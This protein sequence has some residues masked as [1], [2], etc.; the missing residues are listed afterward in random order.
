MYVNVQSLINKLDRL[1]ILLLQE[2]YHILCFSEHW[3]ADDVLDGVNLEGYSISSCYCRKGM[4]HGGVVVYSKALL[5]LKAID[6]GE[7]C[8]DSDYECCCSTF[9]VNKRT[10]ALLLVYRS[11][12]GCYET[13]LDRLSETLNIVSDHCDHIIMCGDI[14]LDVR[15]K[16]R[17]S[18][19]T[20]DI[21]ESFELSGNFNEPTRVA[22]D[23]NG[24]RSESMIDYM[25]TNVSERE[26]EFTL[27]DV[28]IADHYA[29]IMDLDV[30][31]TESQPK[32]DKVTLRDIR[33]ENLVQ[34]KFQLSLV[35]WNDVL[36]DA[37]NM[38]VMF[39]NFNYVFNLIYDFACPYVTRKNS[40]GSGTWITKELCNRRSE[41]MDWFY[42]SKTYPELITVYKLKKREYAQD[43]LETKKSYFSRR[44]AGSSN[45]SRELWRCV[46]DQL[47]RGLKNT[48][49]L[50]LS[51]EGVQVTLPDQVCDIFS[52]HFTSS[53]ANSINSTFGSVK[54]QKCTLSSSLCNTIIF[55]PISREEILNSIKSLKMKHSTGIDGLHVG[56][57][58]F[59]ADELIDPLY[60]LF[61]KSID[62]GV[63]PTALKIA[64][65]IPVF[66][67]NDPHEITNYRPISIQNVLSKVFESVVHSRLTTFF[68]KY[69][70]FSNAQHGFLPSKSTE[71]ASINFLQF[72]YD[73]RDEGKLVAGVFFDLSQAFD[74]LD[75]EFVREKFHAVG[76]R[77]QILDWI[78]SYLTERVSHVFVSGAV[79]QPRKI[80]LGIPQGSI[81]GPLIFTI[82]INDLPGAFTTGHVTLY[83][84]DTSVA[85]SADS[86]ENLGSAVGRAVTEM[87]NWCAKNRLLLNH[88]KTV[89]VNFAYRNPV[90]LIDDKL[91]STSV[92]FLGTF[93]DYRLTFEEQVSE[94]CK[95]I[96]K[97]YF[98]IRQLKNSLTT[99]YLLNIYYALIN[100]VLCYNVLIWGRAQN[101]ERVLIAQK[102]V[103][104]LIFDV[105]YR[106]SCR[107][108]FI[109][110]DILT[111]PSIYIYKAVQYVHTKIISFKLPE[112]GYNTRKNQLYIRRH[113]TTLFEKSPECSF[114]KLYNALPASLRGITEIKK[115]KSNV[116]QYL[117]SKCFYSYN[118]FFNDQNGISM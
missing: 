12:S 30:G 95:K 86:L 8:I 17:R 40:G 9:V 63:F 75:L 57:L 118:E 23:C 97:N 29:W 6:L 48:K 110:R 99:E 101:Y 24:K 41:L 54:H 114:T 79:S 70:I 59:V 65:T 32:K 77:G 104:R 100:S 74:S 52:K 117:L 10:Y 37:D 91:F 45:V 105:P 115:F 113:K 26:R 71:T 7:L 35:D 16:C 64:K 19:L 106:E 20:L 44:I 73:Q 27:R 62:S 96:N 34:L 13:F 103:L 50:S 18:D 81:L 5:G 55:E 53:A 4:L 56:T 88:A 39:D 89:F 66:K 111:F 36:A 14:N 22:I 102:R 49:D 33:E 60:V 43:I 90:S 42:L 46:N 3:L 92:K 84:D 85:V 69:N 28:S 76:I 72:V 1:H 108:I 94:V 68:N 78:I 15:V 31:G 80:S 25:I 2:D 82:F 112:N 61:N 51:V 107:P 87:S 67:K 47:K 21:F 11:P 98:A 83:A 116:K 93:V 109:G 38:D 58:K